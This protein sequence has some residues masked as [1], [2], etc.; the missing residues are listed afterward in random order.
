MTMPVNS[1]EN[2][3]FL[4]NGFTCSIFKSIPS[5]GGL[6]DGVDDS[7]KDYTIRYEAALLLERK[8]GVT[9]EAYKQKLTKTIA[10]KL[11]K[12][13]IKIDL[14]GLK[15]FGTLLMVNNFRNIITTNYDNA[16][17]MILCEICGYTDCTPKTLSQ[18]SVYSLR[19]YAEYQNAATGHRVRIWHIHGDFG[20]PKS[21]MLGFDQYCNSLSRVINYIKGGFRY[22][23]RSNVKSIPIS[24]KCSSGK[25]D[26]IS[27]AELM[28]RTNVYIVG[29]G[30]KL[31]EIDVWWVL[32]KRARMIQE[33]DK[34]H[35]RITYLYAE[36]YTDKEENADVFAAMQ[37]FGI[38]EG[39]LNSETDYISSIFEW[40]K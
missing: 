39:T 28:F 29:F 38:K 24:V 26:H 30:M 11:T 15:Q 2:T 13:N 9:E 5:W 34:V 25:F 8:K 14:D 19:T 36:Q 18:E 10:E 17:E 37:A 33:K 3:L 23:S 4:G 16:I 20:R 32:N 40:V 31:S 6:F 12:E 21:I 7:I 1:S 27:W 35:N 22:S